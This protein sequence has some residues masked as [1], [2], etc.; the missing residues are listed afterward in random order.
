[1]TLSNQTNRVSATGSGSTG[2]EVP[3]S[4]PINATSDLVVYRRVTAT[5][6]QTLLA[7][8]TDYTVVISGTSGG[9]LTTVTTIET[10]E[11]I[12]IIRDTPDT[13]S[14]DLVQGG[15][16]NAEN[17]E[18]ALDKNTKLI[19][20]KEDAISRTPSFPATDPVSSISD[21]PNSIDRISKQAGYDSTGK[22]NAISAVPTGSVAFTAF[23]TDLVE[24]ADA[25]A[26]R[27]VLGIQ[28]AIFDNRDFDNISAAISSIGATVGELHIWDTETLTESA[29]FP[30]TLNVVIHKG[31]FITKASTYTVT[32]DGQLTAGPYQ[33]F[34]GFTAGD[35]TLAGRTVREIYIQWWEEDAGDG[36]QDCAPAFRH[37]IASIPVLSN[38]GIIQLIA[39]KYP[40]E[41]EIV[42]DRSG[43]RVNGVQG[44]GNS[45]IDVE[46]GTYIAPAASFAGDIFKF[47]T[48]SSTANNSSGVHNLAFRDDFGSGPTQGRNFSINS[49]IHVHDAGQFTAGNLWFEEIKGSCIKETNAI[50]GNFTGI[51]AQYCG[52]TGKPSLDLDSAAAGAVQGQNWSNVRIENTFSAAAIHLGTVANSNHFSNF[53]LEGAD[54]SAATRG[55]ILV[56]AGFK[57]TFSNGHI[58][59]H[60]GDAERV[61]MT[62]DF[63]G[64]SNIVIGKKANGSPT[65]CFLI[66]GGTNNFFSNIFNRE[67]V[68]IDGDWYMFKLS[69]N[70]DN[71]VF[72]G[73]GL[74][75][76]GGWDIDS[77]CD[78][79]VVNSVMFDAPAQKLINCA[80]TFCRFEG[81][82]GRLD[83]L[84]AG[85]LVTLGG[86]NH[87]LSMTAGS[88]DGVANVVNITGD[89][90]TVSGLFETITN[91]CIL[92]DSGADKTKIIGCEFNSVGTAIT[93]NGSNTRISVDNTSVD[94]TITT[95][96]QTLQHWGSTSINTTV[97]AI[98]GTLGSG[99]FI[100]EVKT[101]I[102]TVDNGDYTLSVTNHETSDPEAFVFAN[103]DETLILMWSGTEWVTIKSSATP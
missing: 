2:Q 38:G 57:D 62:G 103:V 15:S 77:G 30:D 58:N 9:T 5:G 66:Q 21:L 89:R 100:G 1:M 19:I 83:V 11:Q 28:D 98:G 68:A 78:H 4:F 23:G 76:M 42:F 10:T 13:Q 34:N 55:T 37:T 75:H 32:F 27:T 96:A 84:A 101:V 24:A 39:G 43:I 90:C 95:D 50:G 85:D 14:L 87:Y 79:N 33:I 61:L 31:G 35:V 12:H 97:G 80:G 18:T 22:P 70:S 56:V 51:Y 20:E 29:T 48:T 25:A 102:M 59:A 47:T 44:G 81:I 36:S 16:F 26:G 73:I 7:E 52:D 3:F 94:E 49:C 65:E 88:L 69:S 71:N 54:T 67:E 6:V 92:I 82:S 46:F 41:S 17:V 53:V 40:V 64:F 99:S 45:G 93:D 72:T 63:C 74:R 91:V 60:H 86:N 8:T